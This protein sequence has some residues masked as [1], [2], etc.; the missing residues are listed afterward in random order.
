MN[1][2]NL[3]PFRLLLA[4]SAPI[5]AFTTT[6]LVAQCGFSWHAGAPA[7]GP[8]GTVE[9]VLP[10]ANGEIVAGGLFRVADGEVTNNVAR[11]DGV[12]WHALGSGTN[13]T[14]TCLARLPNG[15]LV[16]GGSFTFAGGQ[17]CNRIARWDGTTWS[18][19]GSG[20]DDVPQV[21]LGLPNGDL[22][23]GGDFATAGGT[24]VDN[25]AVWNGI[26]W[27]PLGSGLP[28]SSVKAITRLAN[29]D[30]V[31]GG[32]FFAVGLA[33]GLQ[34]WNGSNWLGVPG[35]D[36]NANA[37]VDDLAVRGNGD[38]VVTGT[39]RING[40]DERLAVW[41]GTTMQPLAAPLPLP[42]SSQ[43]M[44]T[45]TGMSNGDVLVGGFCSYQSMARWDGVA[46][47]SVAGGPI[48]TNAVCEDAAGGIVVT[49]PTVSNWSPHG[50]RRFDGAT[51]QGLG[52]NLPPKVNA[53][54]AL[55][56]GDAVVAGSFTAIEG[57]ATN[58]IA[59]WNGSVW[60][61]LGLGVDAEVTAVTTAANG[62]VIAAGRFLN[63][64]GAPANHI[65]RW[66]GQVWSTLGVGIPL[67][68]N[69]WVT[70]VAVAG[71]GAIL[72]SLYYGNVLRF[73]GLQWSALAF[74]G[75]PPNC[76]A[77]V[78]FGNGD[79]ILAGLFLAPGAI[80]GVL[81]YTGGALNLIP[82]APLFA[83]NLFVAD[84]GAV[85]VRGSQELLRWDGAGWTTLP[86]VGT[87]LGQLPNGE[88]I[89][90]GNVGGAAPSCLY[91]LRPTG[92]ESFGN[93]FGPGTAVLATRRGEVM[94][95]GTFQTVGSTVCVGFAR[96]TPT[97]AAATN[98]VGAGCSGGAGPV[99][100]RVDR[101]AWVGGTLRATANG[102]TSDSLAVQAFGV[103]S[104][105]LPL[106]SGA[107]GCSLFV[108]PI[109]TDVLPTSGG[110]ALSALPI[111]N[112]PSL[113]GQQLLLQVV[114][115]ELAAAGIV[116]LTST[117]ALQVTIGAL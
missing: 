23:A 31:V 2:T 33:Q 16:A 6:P 100:L 69:D 22:V 87:A 109:L 71:D 39:F 99:T 10:L 85:I 43:G 110:A 11:W 5:L 36:T 101:D 70:A 78:T 59:R 55:P 15:D 30:L 98:V 111:P 94:V 48:E 56:D 72:A 104:A 12:T 114:G 64:G 21:L 37:A 116:R 67:L 92:W 14:V 1:P 115:V 34:R 61:P 27:S 32:W 90:A 105:L 91:R 9:A 68:N 51:W 28:N 88:L 83:S 40:V 41:N 66:N 103:Q 93:L 25:I 45:T 3:L 52:A 44:L 63:A 35:F 60:S 65:A 29:G 95:A 102:M 107:P 112:Q 58:H 50:V 82:G 46:W 81:R 79:V 77:M 53:M 7:A 113:A 38:V 97:C 47:Q 57:V 89:A 74:P 86:N 54:T 73:D 62:D 17:Q 18:P 4:L 80:T 24:T 117:N 49:T 75:Q 8:R 106:P 20:L 13:G 108:L 42:C 76:K 96:A 26:A 19:L 84:D